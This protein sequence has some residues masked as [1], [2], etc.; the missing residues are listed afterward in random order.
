MVILVG[1]GFIKER[2]AESDTKFIFKLPLFYSFLHLK[3]D[4]FGWWFMFI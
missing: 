2:Q 1:L 4:G 3:M